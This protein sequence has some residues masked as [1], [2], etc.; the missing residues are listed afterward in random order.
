MLSG[1]S[2]YIAVH[3]DRKRSN[4]ER[5]RKDTDMTTATAAKYPAGFF[6]SGAERNVGTLREA[7]ADAWADYRAYRATLAELGP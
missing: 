6:V 2:V 1:G 3:N 4:T 7:S 5:K